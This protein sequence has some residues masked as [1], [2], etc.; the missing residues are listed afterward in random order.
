MS[1]RSRD[2]AKADRTDDEVLPL[3]DRAQPPPS[4][5]LS[6]LSP[7]VDAAGLPVPFQ[8]FQPAPS[9]SGKAEVCKTSIPGSNPGGASK[10]LKKSASLVA[11]RHNLSRV[12][13]SQIGLREM[14]HSHGAVRKCLM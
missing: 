5:G 8:K 6:L 2:A 3:F 12:S 10:I 1:R 9:P 13:C 11:R 7:P 4:G 14:H